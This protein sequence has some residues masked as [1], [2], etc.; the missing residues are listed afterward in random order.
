MLWVM[1]VFVLKLFEGLC[2]VTVYW[3]VDFAVC[4]VPIQGDTNVS[5]TNPVGAKRIIGFKYSFL[6]LY[7]L[8]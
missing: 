6:V 8:P 4:V 1:W 5:I 2:E 7:T 3:Q